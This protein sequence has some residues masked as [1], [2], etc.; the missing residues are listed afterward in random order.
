M[1]IKL[2]KRDRMSK[3]LYVFITIMIFCVTLPVQVLAAEEPANETICPEEE[4]ITG[5]ITGADDEVVLEETIL[6]NEAAQTDIKDAEVRS[7]TEPQKVIVTFNPN[8]G[9]TEDYNS[10]YNVNVPSGGKITEKPE[11]PT[12]EGYQFAGWAY[13]FE[14]D[15]KPLFWDFDE[16]TVADYNITLWAVWEKVFLVAFDPNDGINTDYN[17]FYK[18]NVPSGGKITEKPENPT[19]EGYQFAGWAYAFE[20]DNKPL[21]WDFDEDTIADYNITLWAVWEKVFLVAFDPND[22]INTDFNSFYK[23]NVPSGGKITEKPENPTREGYQFAGWAYAFEGDNKPLF[24]DF[25]EDTIADYNITLW[26]VWEKVFFVAFDPNDGIN[27]DFNSFYKA[28]VPSG[29]KITEKPE[30]PTREGYQFAGWAYAFEGDNKP[31]FWD[32]DKDT[33]ADYNITLWAAWEKEDKGT[34]ADKDDKD[35]KED[36]GTDADKDDKDNKDV[37]K[38]GNKKPSVK[39][40]KSSSPQ[41]IRKVSYNPK[42]SDNSNAVL[43]TV[44][45]ASALGLAVLAVLRKRKGLNKH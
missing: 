28:N 42:T 13:V 25:D 18:A 7:N 30:N 17:S 3:L 23:A 32:F 37:S 34:D 43:W 22:G 14:G 31:L 24:W 40:Y 19:R 41:V 44:S 21:F 35:N 12:R 8:D 1:K 16:D 2:H 11:N 10:F 26:A 36:K 45:G 6:P 38:P 15:N 39:V 20:G 27:T 29:G 5:E 9:E 33:V 4:S